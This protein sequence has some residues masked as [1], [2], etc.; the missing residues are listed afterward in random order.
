MADKV[1]GK[2]RGNRKA[3]RF[4]APK[5]PAKNDPDGMLRFLTDVELEKLKCKPH[6]TTLRRRGIGPKVQ[7]APERM[8]GFAKSKKLGSGLLPICVATQKNGKPCTMVALKGRDKC[9]HHD[10]Y[11]WMRRRVAKGISPYPDRYVDEK[12][13]EKLLWQDTIP[14]DL[15]NNPLFTEVMTR[16]MTIHEPDFK[17]RMFCVAMAK[18]LLR[19]WALAVK[20]DPHPWAMA[21]AKCREAGIGT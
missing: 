20:G 17:V 8:V 2:R 21:A 1:H 19:G 4:K 7:M 11:E 5:V 15:R 10:R 13:L 3:T 18:E 12:R 6:H 14:D 9:W 16:R